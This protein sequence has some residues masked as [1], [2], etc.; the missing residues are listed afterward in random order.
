[1]G[2]SIYN[3]HRNADMAKKIVTQTVA[4]IPVEPNWHCHSALKN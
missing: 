3:L 4:K 2:T 1:M